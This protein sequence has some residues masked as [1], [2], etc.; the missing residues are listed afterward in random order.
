MYPS[1]KEITLPIKEVDELIS[2]THSLLGVEEAWKETNESLSLDAEEGSDFATE[3]F[4]T[5][6]ANLTESR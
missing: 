6:F 1:K 5:Q 4:Q 2:L 3:F